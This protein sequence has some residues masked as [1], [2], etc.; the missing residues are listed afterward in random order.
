MKT[1]IGVDNGVS[2]SIGIITPDSVSYTPTPIFEYTNYQKTLKKLNRINVKELKEL[3]LKSISLNAHDTLDAIV[4]IER[5][6]VNPLRF[7]ASTSALRALEA[8]LIV[9]EGLKIPYQ[10][11]DSK[12]WQKE[13]LPKV[14]TQAIPKDMPAKEKAVICYRR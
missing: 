14:L 6:M 1:R 12:E 5:P 2:G 3:F 10:F 13:L 9:I 4:L 8:T 11:I 7:Q